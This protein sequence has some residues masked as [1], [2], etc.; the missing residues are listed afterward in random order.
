[1]AKKMRINDQTLSISIEEEHPMASSGKCK[2]YHCSFESSDSIFSTESYVEESAFSVKSVEEEY[3]LRIREEL[4]S[5]G[6]VV[7]GEEEDGG[8]L[9]KSKAHFEAS[10]SFSG[11]CRRKGEKPCTNGEMQ[12]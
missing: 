12:C 4:W 2:G 10:S 8:E 5:K 9:Q 11:A 1:V 6:K 3:N 7:G